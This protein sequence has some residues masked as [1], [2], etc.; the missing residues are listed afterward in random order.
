MKKPNNGQD[1]ITGRII[2][3]GYVELLSPSI[4]GSGN[5]E[6]A[7]IE[8]L[9]DADT[10]P[11]IPAT[12]LIGVLKH[13]ISKK[14]LGFS[15]LQK[16]QY[17]FLLGKKKGE[18]Q[19]DKYDFAAAGFVK[20][21]ADNGIISID[22]KDRNVIVFKEKVDS[23]EKRKQRLKKAGFND[24]DIKTVSDVWEYSYAD[25]IQSA[26]SC[27]DLTTDKAKIVIRDGIKINPKTGVVEKKE[28]LGQKYNYEVIEPGAKF[29]LHWEIVLREAFEKDVFKR[30]LSTMREALKEGKITIGAST[31]KGFG[32]CKL[33]DWKWKYTELNFKENLDHVL[34]WIKENYSNID[35]VLDSEPFPIQEDKCFAIDAFFS[36]KNSLIIKSYP[37]NLESPDA[38]HI[39]SSDED[40]LPGTSVRGA[41]RSRALRILKTLNFSARK[42][43][44][45]RNGIFGNVYEEGDKKID[46][47]IKDKIKGRLSVEETIINTEEGMVV[48]ELQNRIKIDRFTGG[49]IDGALFDSMPL[50][51]GD[52][53]KERQDEGGKAITISFKLR[54]YKD[55]EAG[56]L[57]QVLKDLW[58]GDLPIG[59][60]KN[61]GRGVL[62]GIEANIMIN[63][64][65][66]ISLKAGPDSS[67]NISPRNAR[68]LNSFAEAL[69]TESEVVQ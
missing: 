8:V 39:K 68:I 13:S 15:F 3:D 19:A 46:K 56:L 45:I 4:I 59:G 62:Q 25:S 23:E 65:S 2:I 67:L 63:T 43:E 22:N 17:D 14:K 6:L 12:S 24:S 32:R 34:A 37:S 10:N 61:V 9:R 50:W 49:V 48:P 31:N 11:F 36:I 27:S 58:T 1:K 53:G 33:L 57:L 30:I 26:L 18:G 44:E 7:D 52:K 47:D 69:K 21:L 41:I 29:K 60:E 20:R 28:K 42:F 40:V 64:E 54:D 5:N 55:L 38:V 35:T 66:P 51:Q 16:K